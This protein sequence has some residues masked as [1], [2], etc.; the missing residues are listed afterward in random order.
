[1]PSV[2]IRYT[3]RGYSARVPVGEE[4]YQLELEGDVDGINAVLR[5]L[6]AEQVFDSPLG[7]VGFAGGARP[8]TLLFEFSVNLASSA[9]FALAAA[10]V[11]RLARRHG[12]KVRFKKH[13]GKH[14]R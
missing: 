4:Q 8:S 10:A 14:R 12:V 11:K 3:P 2:H 1:M 6:D 9:T 7:S 13:G 5:D